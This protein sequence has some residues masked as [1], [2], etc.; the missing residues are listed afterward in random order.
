MKQATLTN[1]VNKKQVGLGLNSGQS[2]LAATKIKLNIEAQSSFIFDE[3]VQGENDYVARN[4]T[5]EDIEN[6]TI[7]IIGASAFDKASKRCIVCL[8]EVQLQEI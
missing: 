1:K 8:V 4:V 5:A 6:S 3:E 2:N 7:P